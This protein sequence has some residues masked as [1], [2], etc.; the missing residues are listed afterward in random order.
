MGKAALLWVPTALFGMKA[1]FKK[2]WTF[3]ESVSLPS[4]W[5]Y[6]RYLKISTLPGFPGKISCW[7]NATFH[8]SRFNWWLC[9]LFCWPFDKGITAGPVYTDTIAPLKEG[10]ATV[11]LAYI[12][13]LSA[14]NNSAKCQGF[15][16]CP[17][18]GWSL[19]V[20]VIPP[21]PLEW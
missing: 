3:A 5:R 19:R 14:P 6:V 10:C 4:C 9:M 11:F 12:V 8:L 18:S 21:G 16:F 1:H 15:L 17:R 7:I 20:S 2:T 13:L